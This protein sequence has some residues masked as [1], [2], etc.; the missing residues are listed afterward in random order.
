MIQ[1]LI[2]SGENIESRED[3]REILNAG[4]EAWAKDIYVTKGRNLIQLV[5]DSE[6][7]VEKTLIDE[8]RAFRV[9]NNPN[10]YF[11]G[12]H[13]VKRKPLSP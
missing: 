13:F 2:G 4:G 3:Y 8:I 11:T 7:P 9:A 1:T 12:A 6:N 10:I 5:S